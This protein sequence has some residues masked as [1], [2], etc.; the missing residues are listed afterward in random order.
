MNLQD[1]AEIVARV[2]PGREH[3]T[4]GPI[5]IGST[6]ATADQGAGL[7]LSGVKTATSSPFWEFPDGRLPFESALSVLL[8]GQGN[9]RAVVETVAVEIMPFDHVSDDFAF[10]Y[11]EGNQSLAW[12]RSEIGRWYRDYAAR[13]GNI[14]NGDTPVICERIAV[15]AHL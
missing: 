8:D 9:A 15:V 1:C 4:F 6:S 7:I 11:G 3:Q 5:S 12:F 13:T 2:L 14:F 10:A